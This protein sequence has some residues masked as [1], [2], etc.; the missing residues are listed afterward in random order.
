MRGR[1]GGAALVKRKAGCI[2]FSAFPWLFWIFFPFFFFFFGNLSC[3]QIA[4]KYATKISIVWELSGKWNCPKRSCV[5][6]C[7][8]VYLCA[9]RFV[10][11]WVCLGMPVCVY[12]A[13]S[14]V[15]FCLCTYVCTC[16]WVRSPFTCW[17]FMR[18]FSR[19]QWKIGA[20]Q[21]SSCAFREVFI[22]LLVSSINSS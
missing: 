1:G 2:I 3:K 19:T 9:A 17:Q 8:C 22:I 5:C 15:S 11:V 10:W 18:F 4:W 12:L 21:L 20:N 13:S 6:V 16:V 14:C 7:V